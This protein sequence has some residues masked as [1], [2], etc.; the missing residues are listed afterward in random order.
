L[1]ILPAAAQ[2]DGDAEAAVVDPNGLLQDVQ[3]NPLESF[4]K[5]SDGFTGREGFVLVQREGLERVIQN[6]PVH[7]VLLSS[8][9]RWDRKPSARNRRQRPLDRS[10]GVTAARKNRDFR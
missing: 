6:Q 1:G 10:A 4:S 3:A 8:G 7:P 9:G 2:I 5:A